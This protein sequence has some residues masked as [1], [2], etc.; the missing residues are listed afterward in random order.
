MILILTP[1]LSSVRSVCN[2]GSASG[3]LDLTTLNPFGPMLISV[4]LTTMTFFFIGLWLEVYYYYYYYFVKARVIWYSGGMIYTKK[5]D[6]GTTGLFGTKR[7]VSKASALIQAIGAVDE[8]NS[9]LGI[10]ISKSPRPQGLTLKLMKVQSDLF[11]IGSMLAGAEVEWKSRRVEEFEREIDQMEGQLPVQTH[12]ILPGGS[13]L[14]AYLFYARALVRRA[15]RELVNAKISGPILQY[16]NRLS[17]F[18]FTLARFENYNHTITE[19][20]ATLRPQ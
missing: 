1:S 8:A 10:V 12:F 18:L 2:S 5:G 17:D 11:A 4:S 16:I 3:A 19:E 13:E 7:R 6:G 20:L 14:S 9:Y 15:E